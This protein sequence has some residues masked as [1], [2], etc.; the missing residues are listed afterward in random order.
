[1]ATMRN[2]PDAHPIQKLLRPHFRYTMAINTRAREGLIN[3]TGIIAELLSIGPPAELMR[4]ASPLFSVDWT[5]IEESI[6]RRGLEDIPGYHYRDDGLKVFR[7]IK[8]YVTKVINLFYTSDGDVESDDELKAWVTDIYTTA[9]PGYFGGTQGH[10]FPKVITTRD[11][12]IKRCTVIIFTGSA[13][14]ASI[15]FGQYAIYG[16]VPNAPLTLR[17]P[18]PTKKGIT[19]YQALV[20]TLPAEKDAKTSINVTY[21]LSQHSTNEVNVLV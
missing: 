10:G 19:D 20:D 16:F 17:R 2:L 11:E 14:H 3:D 12:L 1:M 6:K 8:E 7:A 5:N 18:P 15:N 13:Q 21:A 9:F 4:K